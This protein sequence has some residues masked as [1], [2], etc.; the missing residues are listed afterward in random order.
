MIDA[1]VT[2]DNVVVPETVRFVMNALEM[3]EVPDTVRLRLIRALPDTS[4]VVVGALPIPN[5]IPDISPCKNGAVQ[6]VEYTRKVLA[7][8]IA[9][10]PLGLLPKTRAL[11]K[12]LL[13]PAFDPMKIPELPVLNIPAFVPIPIEF[14]PLCFHKAFDPIP[15]TLAPEFVVHAPSPIAT[16]LHAI[17]DHPVPCPIAITFE[18]ILDDP[19]L[20]PMAMI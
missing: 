6:S 16:T 4:R 15:I 1:V 5:R 2:P 13:D 3:V 20:S 8:L 7:A 11:E 19:A 10:E 14:S 9:Y 17:L 12:V 18:P